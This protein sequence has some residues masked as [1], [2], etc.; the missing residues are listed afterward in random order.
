MMEGISFEQLIKQCEALVS[1]KVY[2]EISCSDG[3]SYFKFWWTDVETWAEKSILL[4]LGNLEINQSR[5]PI[6]NV[7]ASMFKR[8]VKP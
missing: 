3:V 4:T 1:N 5:L 7:L 8:S 6:N 2:L